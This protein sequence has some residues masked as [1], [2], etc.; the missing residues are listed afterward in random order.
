MSVELGGNKLCM[1]MDR[2][3]RSVQPAP[4]QCVKSVVMSAT[5]VK[6]DLFIYLTA[7]QLSFSMHCLEGN[8]LD[9]SV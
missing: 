6:C 4:L 1:A 9:A 2:C 5:V 7:Y 8:R 3:M